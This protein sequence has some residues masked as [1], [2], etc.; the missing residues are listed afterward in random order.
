MLVTIDG[1][2][3]RDY[4]GNIN[5]SISSVVVVPKLALNSIVIVGGNISAYALSQAAPLARLI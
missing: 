4:I 1:C 3:Q 2:S 5:G